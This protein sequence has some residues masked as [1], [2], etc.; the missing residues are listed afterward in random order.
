MTVFHS[1]M[2]SVYASRDCDAGSRV[3]F[4]TTNA[5]FQ[6]W[7]TNGIINQ[8]DHNQSLI[9]ALHLLFYIDRTEPAQDD[10]LDRGHAD[11]RACVGCHR[12]LDPMRLYF[13]KS[14]NINYQRPYGNGVGPFW[15]VE[16]SSPFKV[17]A[18]TRPPSFA[19]AGPSSPVWQSPGT[20][21]VF[22]RQ[23]QSL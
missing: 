14:Y 20:E 4:F 5:F 22:I 9:T 21:I 3:G 12:H 13:S 8:G 15:R 19:S 11:Q 7:P 23:F 16:R 1:M 18:K 2:Y 10:G 17:D 6:N